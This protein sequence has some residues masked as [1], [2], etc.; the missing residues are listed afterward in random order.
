M[1]ALFLFAVALTVNGSSLKPN[2]DRIMIE[3]S[4]EGVL[5][6]A[7]KKDA[8]CISQYLVT[9]DSIYAVDLSNK[10]RVIYPY[11]EEEAFAVDARIS[12]YLVAS[13]RKNFSYKVVKHSKTRY[14]VI[15]YKNS[16][17]PIFD[18]NLSFLTNINYLTC[19]FVKINNNL[20]LTNGICGYI[21]DD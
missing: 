6:C 7:L 13:D 16:E 8:V 17:Q 11:F 19:E 9:P 12:L 4:T 14:F 5:Q 20:K 18:N 1:I 3:S 10:K 15:F 2:S 21:D